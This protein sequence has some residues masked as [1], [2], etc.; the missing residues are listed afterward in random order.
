MFFAIECPPSFASVS[1]LS[2]LVSPVTGPRRT[3]PYTHTLT[4]PVTTAYITHTCSAVQPLHTHS[5]P[6]TWPFSSSLQRLRSLS[7]YLSIARSPFF[8]YI[9]ASPSLAFLAL[10]FATFPNVFFL[11]CRLLPWLDF[12]SVI[13]SVFCMTAG[14]SFFFFQS[15]RYWFGLPPKQLKEKTAQGQ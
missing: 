12:A 7:A 9:I 3:R 8:H 1:P 5:H 13:I 4:F 2:C 15:C 6:R 10:S 11:V 14:R